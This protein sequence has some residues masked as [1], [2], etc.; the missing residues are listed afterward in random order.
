MTA[1]S[2]VDMQNVSADRLA[3]IFDSLDTQPPGAAPTVLRAA[4][5]GEQLWSRLA[6]S[7][8]GHSLAQ[9]TRQALLE[10]ASAQKLETLKQELKLRWEGCPAAD[11]GVVMLFCHALIARAFTLHGEW[12]TSR[13]QEA[14]M[15]FYEDL[16][17]L[18]RQTELGRV[19]LDASR[20]ATRR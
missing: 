14:S 20:Q 2:K 10:S 15:P 12:I 11:Q 8:V 13:K 4:R 1:S 9:S 5:L 6:D 3:A 17:L 16:A 7:P 18:L 19:F